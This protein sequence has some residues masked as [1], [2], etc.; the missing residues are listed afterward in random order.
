[1]AGSDYWWLLVKMSLVIAF[2]CLASVF[3][4][5]VPI[6]A[7]PLLTGFIFRNSLHINVK[8]VVCH[9]GKNSEI[10]LWTASG[11][12]RSENLSSD[13]INL[14]R[15]LSRKCTLIK[16]WAEGH[17][18]KGRL[19]ISS[20]PVIRISHMGLLKVYRT[21]RIVFIKKYSN[22]YGVVVIKTIF[23]QL[24]W[25]GSHLRYPSCAY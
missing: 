2:I 19:D 20:N 24:Q 25:L 22:K 5:A 1:M 8:S 7:V 12:I 11:N 17:T 21:H 23:L 13:C 16:R 9:W 3:T 6:E 18:A 4:A 15:R 14:F 10:L